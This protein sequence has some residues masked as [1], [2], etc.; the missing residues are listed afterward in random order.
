VPV[1]AH[2]NA[3][4]ERVER[5]ALEVAREVQKSVA[6]AVPGVDPVLR[7]M[8]F[9]ESGINFNVV[10]RAQD[11]PSA[12]LVKHEFIKRLHRRYAAEG[13]VIPYP[14]RVVIKEN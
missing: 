3:D 14:T 13:I 5:V 7:Y 9:G 4:L 1:S 8:G 11:F 6:G 12:A 2:Y 10:L